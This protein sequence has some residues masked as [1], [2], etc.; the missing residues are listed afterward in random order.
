MRE[1]MP[2]C[3]GVGVLQDISD[4]SSWNTLVKWCK[5]PRSLVTHACMM[6]L[7]CTTATILKTS[8]A[9]AIFL[10]GPSSFS[11]LS[12]SPPFPFKRYFFSFL[13]SLVI[14][15]CRWEYCV[16]HVVVCIEQQLS[17]LQACNLADLAD[18]IHKCGRT[19][20]LNGRHE[21]KSWR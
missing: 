6:A 16:L 11:F 15:K 17:A 7:Q 2:L 14:L 12:S 13:L 5:I 1:A 8:P 19:F 18:I 21:G 4:G 9:V 3:T 10:Q 20:Q